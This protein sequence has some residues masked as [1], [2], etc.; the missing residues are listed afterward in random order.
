MF[1][2]QFEMLAGVFGGELHEFDRRS[3][4]G[5]KPRIFQA[6][7]QIGVDQFARLV[8]EILGA[9]IRSKILGVL[10]GCREGR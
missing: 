6:G 7:V 9:M 2:D 5:E 10:G 1:Y 3:R 8:A 4:V